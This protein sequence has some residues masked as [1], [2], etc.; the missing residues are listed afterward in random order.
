MTAINPDELKKRSELLKTARQLVTKEYLNRRAELHQQWLANSE[1][2]WRTNGAFLPFPVGSLYPSEEEIVA[3]ALELYN[4]SVEKTAAI[5]APTVPLPEAPPLAT[6]TNPDI[7][8]T[9]TAQLQ[10][11]YPLHQPIILPEVIEHITP[12]VIPEVE[13]SV[14]EVIVTEPTIEL[15]TEEPATSVDP[16]KHSL[17]R[18]LLSGWLQKNKDKET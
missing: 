8:A 16:N 12:E 2:S 10:S 17:L 3:K 6:V 18:N 7:S 1:T 5:P 13:V 15:P 14:P 9:V 4:Q 11:V